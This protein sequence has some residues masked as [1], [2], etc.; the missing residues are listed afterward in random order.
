FLHQGHCPNLSHFG[1]GE[2]CVLLHL[3]EGGRNGDHGSQPFIA[4]YG[5][6]QVAEEYLQDLRR[7]LL[8]SERFADRRQSE[9][10]RRSDEAF[11]ESGRVVGV[12]RGV[13]VGTQ[14][15]K[16]ITAPVIEDGRWGD[17]VL[18]GALVNLNR[19]SIVRADRA[20]G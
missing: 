9:S 6:R 18:L 15:N 10:R 1:G 2:R 13:C 17:I 20:V 8:W 11:E 12:A 5:V 4:P 19:L 16:A 3:V 14:A 7:A